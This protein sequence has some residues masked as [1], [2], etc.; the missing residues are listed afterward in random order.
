M[1]RNVIFA[2]MVLLAVGLGLM[3]W[4]YSNLLPER[5]VMCATADTQCLDRPYFH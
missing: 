1:E 2:F 5:E 3:A 4:R